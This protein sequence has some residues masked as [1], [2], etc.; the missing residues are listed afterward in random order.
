MKT[1]KSTTEQQLENPAASLPAEH[2]APPLLKGWQVFGIVGALAFIL[3]LLF[4]VYL[5]NEDESWG[6]SL[7]GLLSSGLL[8]ACLLLLFCKCR[9]AGYVLFP[10]IAVVNMTVYY[11]YSVFG[12]FIN[13]QVIASMMETN[14]Q[15]AS[16][17][18]SVGNVLLFLSMLVLPVLIVHYGHQYLSAR[19]KWKHVAI[20]VGM[21]GLSLAGFIPAGKGLDSAK[22]NTQYYAESGYWPLIDLRTN[23]KRVKEYW[24][25]GGK[26]FHE[27]MQLPSMA[28]EESS[29]A[30]PADEEL[31]IILHIGESMRA[32][33]LQINGYSRATTPF[34][35]ARADNLVSF[36]DCHSYGLV[37]RLSIIGILTDAEVKDRAP[38]YASFLDVFN[39]HGFETAAVLS[40]PF[41][42]HDFSL[43]ILCS[44]AAHKAY[45]APED[46]QGCLFDPSVAK[47]LETEA[48]IQG[49]RKFIVFY[50]TGAHAFFRSLPRNKKWTPDEYE[51]DAPLK[52]I[53][54]LI[55]AYDNNILE[56]D[57]EIESI[58]KQLEHKNVVYVH[59]GDHGV[60]LGEDGKFAQANSAK[61]VKNPAFFIWMSDGF[62]K[63]HPQQVENLRAN[64]LK[65][66]S[67]DYILHTL[68]SL[69][70]IESVIKKKEL[71]LTDKEAVPF[72]APEDESIMMEG[73]KDSW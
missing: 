71:D 6:V 20:A 58:L 34:L 22:I 54:A 14:A 37:T 50:D 28:D 56:V 63:N 35:A 46:G 51:E 60:A 44:K 30:M 57:I 17:Y 65:P 25:K 26:L 13:Y 61:P 4:N 41:S 9:W 72:E 15:E 27:I 64:A 23:Y 73:Q 59:V 53:P 5:F 43:E 1:E 39:K 47:L 70:G 55:N 24:K 10:L 45:I 2:S 42:I 18:L 40:K 33:H 68:L 69:G 36:P 32:D 11:V 12:T 19:I 62:K 8:T 16:P 3:P 48:A 49:K 31:I 66:V 29:C 21:F 52:N 67:H 7:T 38:K